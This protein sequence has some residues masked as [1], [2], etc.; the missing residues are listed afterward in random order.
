MKIK[1]REQ[2]HGYLQRLQS[3]M[4]DDLSPVEDLEFDQ[5]VTLISLYEL[6][7]LSKGEIE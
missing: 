4:R 5:L 1:T 6:E 2:D 3:L 7:T